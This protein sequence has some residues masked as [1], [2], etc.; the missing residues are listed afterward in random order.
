MDRHKDEVDMK[1]MNLG[2]TRGQIRDR[3][4]MSMQESFR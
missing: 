4:N 3:L 2:K 1:A